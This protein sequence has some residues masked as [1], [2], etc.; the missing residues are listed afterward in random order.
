MEL[1]GKMDFNP[2]F[3]LGLEGLSAV[4]AETAPQ[5]CLDGEFGVR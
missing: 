5:V 4:C 3:S 2:D 1:A